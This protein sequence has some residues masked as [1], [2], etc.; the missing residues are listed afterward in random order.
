MHV[1]QQEQSNRHVNIQSYALNDWCL[2]QL[3]KIVPGDSPEAFDR[4]FLRC[5]ADDDG[6]MSKTGQERA[7]LHTSDSKLDLKHL[8][9]YPLSI[10][11][12]RL[13][14]EQKDQDHVR[15]LLRF[16][17]RTRTS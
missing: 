12:S 14:N 1:H 9:Q 13:A 10:A 7:S 4:L 5:R 6:Q 16:V 11:E 17:G 3:L 2:L 15:A 8:I